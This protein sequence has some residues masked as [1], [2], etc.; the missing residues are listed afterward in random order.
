M[1]TGKIDLMYAILY[2]RTCKDRQAK[3]NAMAEHLEITAQAKGETLQ[4][5]IQRKQSLARF[6]VQNNQ[7]NPRKNIIIPQQFQYI[8][9]W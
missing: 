7:R 3:N 8:S 6:T 1:V 4:D 2:C 9:E 5:P